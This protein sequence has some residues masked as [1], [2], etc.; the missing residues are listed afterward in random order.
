MNTD[1]IFFLAANPVKA[2]HKFILA[3]IVAA[4]WKYDSSIR[5]VLSRTSA[6]TVKRHQKRKI[7]ARLYLAFQGTPGPETPKGFTWPFIATTTVWKGTGPSNALYGLGGMDGLPKQPYAHPML[8]QFSVG[9]PELDTFEFSI[10][11]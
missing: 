8:R 5:E 9:I 3:T 2:F 7:L 1:I 10:L 4:S 11:A 6:H